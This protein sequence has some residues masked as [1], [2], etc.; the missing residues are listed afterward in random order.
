MTVEQ[1]PD[2][3]PAGRVLGRDH[4]SGAPRPAV[5]SWWQPAG[6]PERQQWS[7]SL[8]E[9]L[10]R[11]TSETAS[12]LR[13]RVHPDDLAAWDAA[14]DRL[15]DDGGP[16]DLAHRVRSGDGRVRRVWSV[17]T[18]VTDPSGRVAGRHGIV[19]DV[20]DVTISRRTH[21]GIPSA[22]ADRRAADLD[23]LVADRTADLAIALRAAES[24][25]EAKS[26]VL[27]SMS[28]E[29]RTPLNAVLGYT[30]LL[31]LDDELHDGGRESLAIIRDA[32]E[33][34]L[35]LVD[36]LIDLSR[37]ES[38]P[39]SDDLVAVDVDRAVESCLAQLAP[40]AAT[41]GLS[42]TYRPQRRGLTVLAEPLHL[43]QV[44]GN[45][46]SNAVKYN[47]DGGAV[48]VR[49]ALDADG[50]VR[51][52]IEDSGVG[53]EMA[54]VDELFEPFNRLGQEYG[55]ID[56]AGIGLSICRRLVEA[57]AGRIEVDSTPGDGST[58]CVVLPAAPGEA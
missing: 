28:H 38:A 19:R 17:L 22:T 48:Q 57:M 16:V 53:F 15:G 11:G 58:F 1:A 30:Q 7:R 13:S 21:V 18:L 36:G 2:D 25:S 43:A 9:I 8:V 44:L 46:V 40:S 47:V 3:R 56:G 49:S 14:I 41:R 6:S 4:G 34:L 12:G 52:E 10:G 5:G 35:A 39:V 37:L 50:A 24:A 45:L 26:N 27:A 33:Q 29:V 20:S 31:L 32:G 55:E 42:S 23:A 54:R 51:I